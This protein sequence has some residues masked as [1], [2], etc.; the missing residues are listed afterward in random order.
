MDVSLELHSLQDVGVASDQG[1]GLGGGEHDV[2]DI[3]YHAHGQRP[4]QDGFEPPSLGL[5]RLEYVAIEAA[6]GEVHKDANARS[7]VD[8]RPRGVEYRAVQHVALPDAPAVAL[9][10]V[11]RPPRSIKV[12]QSCQALLDIDASAE[13]GGR[14]D[15]HP[16]QPI[17]GS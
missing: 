8:H 2:V 16:R 4:T 6:G 10:Q 14:A 1:L 5:D 9:L 7:R 15:D 13:L 17:V 3:L 12:V 11:H